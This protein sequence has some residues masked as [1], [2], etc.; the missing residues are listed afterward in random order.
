[1]QIKTK[2]IHASN[3]EKKEREKRRKKKELLATLIFTITHFA[4]E[5]KSIFLH[6]YAYT[7]TACDQINDFFAIDVGL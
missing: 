3:K 5:K 2:M 6:N 4:E 1:M 7:N